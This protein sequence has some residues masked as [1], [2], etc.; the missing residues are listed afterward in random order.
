MMNRLVVVVIIFVTFLFEESISLNPGIFHQYSSQPQTL[1]TT[2]AGTSSISSNQHVYHG[3]SGWSSGK[4]TKSLP[5]PNVK[6]PLTKTTSSFSIHSNQ[7]Q[8]P[9]FILSSSKSISSN[10]AGGITSYSSHSQS[11]S[12]HLTY[13]LRPKPVTIQQPP[14]QLQSLAYQSNSIATST[15]SGKASFFSGPTVINS[16]PIIH[17]DAEPPIASAVSSSTSTSSVVSHHPKTTDQAQTSHSTKKIVISSPPPPG[18]TIHKPSTPHKST[19]S[20]HSHHPHKKHTE[21]MDASAIEEV[22]APRNTSWTELNPHNRIVAFYNLYLGK[23]DFYPSIVEEQIDLMKA[24]G[25]LNRLDVVYYVS[26]GNSVDSMPNHLKKTLTTKK[27]DSSLF[28][29]VHHTLK[30][31]D[32]TL[33]LS[34]LYDFCVAN[35]HSKVLYFHD[36]GSYNYRGENVFFRQFLDCYVLNPQCIDA[37]EDGFDTCG[38]RLSPIPSPHYSGNFWWAR[39]DYVRKLVHPGSMVLNNTF[40]ELSKGL[41][42]GIASHARYFAEA[43]I[44]SH[45]RVNPAD[46]MDH[47]VD[48]SFFCCY[49]LADIDPKQCPNHARHFVATKQEMDGIQYA[50]IKPKLTAA[51]AHNMN[52]N[53]GSLKIGGKCKAADAFTNGEHFAHLYA[54]K[55]G[56]FE[57]GHHFNMLDELKKR[58]F[59][60]YG[61][62]PTT[63]INAS[64]QLSVIPSLPSRAILI[65]PMKNVAYYYYQNGSV[66][67]EGSLE[68]RS[69]MNKRDIPHIAMYSFLVQKLIH[70]GLTSVSSSKKRYLRRR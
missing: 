4:N 38:W 66:F 65:E 69:A 19:S 67:N 2:T 68:F 3:S 57:F 12:Q 6:T 47:E 27:N 42:E 60:W 70:Q 54:E 49:D 34:Y 46:C 7:D 63:L 21:G 43:W 37:L 52:A 28:V 55:R 11:Q 26:I 1:T 61:E 29:Q 45:P 14:L 9:T 58:S 51:L 40:A 22:K 16:P 39:C 50:D 62:E 20:R 17:S 32:E 13:P 56:Q 15:A 24:T 25:L 5:Q 53:N 64:E 33:T 48:T 36:K 44:A 59:L 23:P 10:H 18:G 8:S 41:S 30:S 35:P 31:V